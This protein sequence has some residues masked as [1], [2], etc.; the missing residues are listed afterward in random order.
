[1][2][3]PQY[4][5]T[6]PRWVK[7]QR[8]FTTGNT[9][10]ILLIHAFIFFYDT[11]KLSIGTLDIYLHLESVKNI[12]AIRFFFQFG[13]LYMNKAV[14]FL[15]SDVANLHVCLLS[16]IYP[17]KEFSPTTQMS[18]KS[19]EIIIIHFHSPAIICRALTIR[20]RIISKR[21]YIIFDFT[22]QFISETVLLSLHQPLLFIQAHK[23]SASGNETLFVWR[24]GLSATPEEG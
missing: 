3:P 6:G 10:N 24:C 12:N 21:I 20:V 8:V 11:Y 16:E 17:L 22:S 4:C 14:L 5:V 19:N 13:V 18:S 9:I 2:L 1:M 7:I 15:N 23:A